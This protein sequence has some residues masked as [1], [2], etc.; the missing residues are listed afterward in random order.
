MAILAGLALSIGL[1]A[2]AMP[3]A[4]ESPAAPGSDPAAP[5]AIS[6]ASPASSLQAGGYY[7]IGLAAPWTPPSPSYR[8]SVTVDG[9]HRLDYA[10]LA[11]AGLPVDALDPRTFRMFYMG[12]EIAIRVKGEADGHFDPGDEILF[13][14][15]TVDSLFYE[16]LLR[17]N[18]YTGTNIF[19]LT[20]G[21]PAGRRMAQTDGSAGGAAPPPFLHR[22]H[23][24]RYTRYVYLNN[25]P[26]LPDAD[27]W[28]DVKIVA[29]N[30]RT[31][32]FQAANL[33]PSAGLTG[34]LKFNLQG[35]INTP[36]PHHIRVSVNGNLV[37]ED[38]TSW[39]SGLPLT[40]QV[41]VPQAYF[42]EG[43]NSITF[44][45]LLDAPTTYDE[46][47]YNWAEPAYY[48][49][50]VAEGDSLLFDSPAPGGWRYDVGGFS[51]ADAEI[52]DVTEML[53]VHQVV[54]ATV[55]GGGPFTIS[56][57][58]PTTGTHRYLVAT[59]ATYKTPTGIQP[60]TRPASAYT[61]IEPIST[62]NRAD[63]IIITHGDFY[64]EAV[65]LAAYR[66]QRYAVALI[67]VQDIY[68]RFN[69]GM[70]SA[71]AIRDF[72]AYAYRYWRPS[73][74]R[75]VV[76]I[77]DGTSDMRNYLRTTPPTYI[78]PFLA[79]VDPDLK[80]TA[81]D[82]LFVTL[83]GDD[84][85]PDMALGRMSVN[86]PAE[87]AAM[88]D[89]VIAYETQCRCGQG[90]DAWNKNTL[91]I[92]DNLA[93]GGGDFYF[94]SDEIA[95]GYVDPPTNSIKLLP[96][97]YTVTKAYLD[98][99]CFGRDDCRSMITNTLNITGALFVNYVGHAGKDYWSFD[100]IFSQEVLPSLTM[101][102][103]LPVYLPMTCYEGSFHDPRR[104]FSSLAEAYTRLPL[105]GAVAS[106]S[107]TG[108]GLVSGH[109][110]LERGLFLALFHQGYETLGE[111]TVRAKQYL[112]DTTTLNRDLLDTFMIFGDPALRIKTAAV[113][114]VPTGLPVARFEGRSRPGAVQLS[115]ETANEADILGFN[116][117]RREAG[118]LAAAQAVNDTPI[119]A[120]WAGSN[121]GEVYTY[122]DATVQMGRTYEYTLEIIKL[123]GGRATHG[124]IIVR[125]A[126][127]ALYLPLIQR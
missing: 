57:G 9:I 90:G 117:L 49:T 54:N 122:A 31:Y 94:Y 30:S 61:P 19:W 67:D 14:A 84:P 55:G 119:V 48:D 39:Y 104:G 123:S 85:V 52:Y 116:L 106:W 82:N 16:G 28:F 50:Y 102:A 109:D 121:Q 114:E 24:E 103:C 38:N 99:T 76:L 34:S 75:F 73:A 79:N 53:D 74:P 100:A 101:S 78:P 60:V 97:T 40:V 124:P 86:T 83:V 112:Y 17:A 20:Y 10:T 93:H 59:P 91:F 118:Q 2:A 110:V 66:S 29:P 13:Y 62:T 35:Y 41:D 88:I 4:G 36:T 7:S 12:Q 47:Y 87:A 115:W 15:R 1:A 21:G 108:S 127:A 6:R 70:M 80:E 33:A 56:F 42:Q 120:S 44:Q 89:K 65:R 81:A 77:G 11:A 45:L 126:G 71:E 43:T 105:Y 3:A 111:A 95:D 26:D 96:A 46:V 68:D 113:C 18:K 72:L 22:E 107:P 92:S 58:D 37:Y 8:I 51:T 5:A 98:L 32:T 27:H 64:T 23:L 25:Y 69:G 125:T 63:Y